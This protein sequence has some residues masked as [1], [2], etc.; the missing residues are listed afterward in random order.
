[1]ATRPPSDPENAGL[2]P[3]EGIEIKVVDDDWNRLPSDTPGE[4][5]IRGASVMTGYWNRPDANSTSFRDGWLRTGDIGSM[6]AA[7]RLHVHDRRSDL[8]LSG[9]ENVYPAEVEAVL[10]EHPAVAEAGVTGTPDETFG[11]RP[12]AWLVANQL[13]EADALSLH[14]HCRSKLAGYKCPVKFVWLPSLPRTANGKL[15]RRKLG[16]RSDQAGE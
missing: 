10:L 7:G 16:S 5:C 4:I 12:V 3:I 13:G 14:E 2:R 9:G 6:D 1:V 15:L 8:I 11:A